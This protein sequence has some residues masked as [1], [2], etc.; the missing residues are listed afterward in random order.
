MIGRRSFLTGGLAGAALWPLAVPVQTGAQTGAQ[1]QTGPRIVALGDSLTDGFGLA[2]SAGLVPVL[3]GWLAARETPARII[4]HGLSGD[5]TWGGRVRVHW[6][7]RRGADAAIIE[8]GG[9]DML[10][11]WSPGQAEANLDVILKVARRG[12]RPVLLVGIHAPGRDRARRQQWAEIWP[13]LALRHGTL[14]LPDL[15]APLAAIPRPD[16]G[17]YLQPDGIHPSARGVALLADHL[18]PAVQDLIRQT[19]G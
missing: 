19:R 18:G 11:G 7:L 5:T 9:N 1:T 2:R 14:L 6:A 17:P 8:L 16:R 13:R 3:Q 15:Y 4:N 12:N 10:L